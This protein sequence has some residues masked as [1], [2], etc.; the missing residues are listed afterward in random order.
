LLRSELS[1]RSPLPV[2][3]PPPVLCTDNGAMI[4]AA[5]YQ[6]LIAGERSGLAMDVEPGLRIG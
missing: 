4:A 5:G 6:R 2:I 3:A 1:R